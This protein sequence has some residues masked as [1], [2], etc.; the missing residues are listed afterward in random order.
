M[1]VPPNSAG[2]APP[3][4]PPRAWA[5]PAIWAVALGTLLPL[6]RLAPAPTERLIGHTLG[7][8]PGHLWMQWLL[9]RGLSPGVPLF[10]QTDVV[11]GEPLWVVPTDWI[12]RAV[13]LVLEPLL[14]GILTYNAI[15]AALLL[16]AGAA[17]VRLAR[18]AGAT[19]WPAALAAL[20]VMWHPALMGFVADGRVDSIGVGW[21]GMLA[22]AWLAAMRTPT[23]RRGVGIGAWAAGVVLSGPNLLVATAMA[24]LAPTAAAV[25]AGWRRRRPLAVAAASSG[26]TAAGVLAT[27]VHVEGND[28]GRLE[29]VSNAEARPLIEAVDPAMLVERRLADAWMGARQLNREVP[30]GSAWAL[31]AVLEDR[32]STVNAASMGTVQPYAPGA[33]WALCVVPW[34]LGLVGLAMRPRAVAPWLA[35][36]VGLQVLALGH[37]SSQTLPLALGPEQYYLAP[38]VLLERIP[39]LSVFNNYGL[40]AVLAS[41]AVACAAA[42]ALSAVPRRWHP[43]AATAA[44]AL[45]IMEVTRGPV[46][47]PLSVTEMPPPAGLIE[48]LAPVAHDHGVVMLPVSKDLDHYLQT[49]HGRPSW[50][51]FRFGEATPQGDPLLASTGPASEA[52]LAAGAGRPVGRDLCRALLA[53]GIGAVVAV[54]AL[55]PRAQGDRL[56]D[57]LHAALGPPDWSDGGR[58]VYR[59]AGR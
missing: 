22:V 52:L 32:P 42:R 37:G 34:G 17:T 4:P 39:G 16:L 45:W 7:E 21:V 53:E 58:Q 40:F 35:A 47:L 23:A 36:A 51:R 11:L 5:D 20:L 9:R 43:W 12:N 48:S 3:S 56:D 33:W 15:V 25:V 13:A 2:D 38:A 24:A 31:P 26:L 55:L 10:G 8:A 6:A 57:G 18:R 49:L 46:P 59:C 30:L 19:P 50:M 29:Q 54:P 28:R 41:L 1:T 14:G 27:L 44:A